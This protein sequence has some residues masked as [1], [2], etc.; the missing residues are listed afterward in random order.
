MVAK[1]AEQKAPLVASR[2]CAEGGTFLVLQS[3]HREEAQT[4]APNEC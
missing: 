3:F 2:R 1:Y 4:L